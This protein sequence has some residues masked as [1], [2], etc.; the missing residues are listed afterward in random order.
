MS[1]CGLTATPDWLPG[2][3]IARLGIVSTG[4]R[5]STKTVFVPPGASPVTQTLPAM[6]SGLSNQVCDS[7][8]P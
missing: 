1:I 8:P 2:S 7:G 4:R 3:W 5:K 6:D